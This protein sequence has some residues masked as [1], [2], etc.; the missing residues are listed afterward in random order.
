MN[1]GERWRAVGLGVGWR[2]SS[3]VGAIV[4]LGLAWLGWP[5]WGSL[6]SPTGSELGAAAPLLLAALTLCLV[7]LAVAIWLDA[8]RDF[9]PLSYCLVLILANTGLRLTIN[10]GAAGIE[11]VHVLPLL[12]GAAAGAPAGFLVGAAGMLFS[13]AVINGVGEMLP[14]QMMVLGLAGAAGGLAWRARPLPAW[15]LSLP[16][17]VITGLGSGVLLN[18]TGWALEPGTTTTSFFPGLPPAQVV[19]RLWEYTVAT[20]LAYDLTRGVTTAVII[21]CLGLPLLR[22]AQLTGL[23]PLAPPSLAGTPTTRLNPAAVSRRDDRD[24]LATMWKTGDPS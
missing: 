22:S 10:P 19:A 16:L 18:L 2:S 11:V 23:R 15:L 12:A 7:A 14:G 13:S 17:A 5:V 3:V 8:G 1:A 21:G 20:S 24:R 6:S 9:G 4:V